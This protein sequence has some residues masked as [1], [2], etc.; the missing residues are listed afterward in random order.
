M[1]NIMCFGDSNTYGVDPVTGNRLERY[2][3]WPGILQK[4]LGEEYYIIEEG[5]G[6]RTTVWEDPLAEDRNG[7]KS[8]KMLLDSHSPLDWVILMLGTNDLKYHFSALPTDVAAGM[9]K[10]VVTILHHVYK[11][12]EHPPK[13]LLL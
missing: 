7:I 4:I 11:E 2:Q 13:I 1:I 9:E 5:L 12:N 6:G 10:L 3:R 8:L